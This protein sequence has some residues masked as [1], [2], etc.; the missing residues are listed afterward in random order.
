MSTHSRQ[1]PDQ[2]I[3]QL[4]AEVKRPQKAVAAQNEITARLRESQALTIQ[5]MTALTGSDRPDLAPGSPPCHCPDLGNA[6][7]QF[8]VP[9]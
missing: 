7:S 3:A 4:T 8:I 9:L 6:F 1:G 2:K 5:A